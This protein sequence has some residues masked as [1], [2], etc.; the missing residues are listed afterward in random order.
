MMIIIRS[1]S[2]SRTRS[3]KPSTT[4]SNKHFGG[5]E[6]IVFNGICPAPCMLHQCT[7]VQS[8]LHETVVFSVCARMGN[9]AYIISIM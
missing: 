8:C 6:I 5:N 1:T 2:S 4:W 7:I 9:A 3:C